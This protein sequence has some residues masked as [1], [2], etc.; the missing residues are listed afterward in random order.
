M[1][2]IGHI[3]L[4]SQAAASVL[5]EFES[6][7]DRDYADRY[8][9]PHRQLQSLYSRAL[10]RYLILIKFPEIDCRAKIRQSKDGR[11]YLD[12]PGGRREID[13]SLSHSHDM[14]GAEVSSVGPIGVDIEYMKQQ[15]NFTAM[16]QYAFNITEGE[17]S[18]WNDAENFYSL[19]TVL[20]SLVKANFMANGAA[21]ELGKFDALSEGG[22]HYLTLAGRVAIIGHKF[23][24]SY[25]MGLAASPAHE[26][27]EI[28]ISRAWPEPRAGDQYVTVYEISV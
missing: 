5:K 10:L 2:F 14:V 18:A 4:T 21:V 16:A 7:D 25:A 26:D 11:P 15:R 28:S 12:L 8:R 20:E 19:W 3:N 1:L 23:L 6:K 13:I 9:R 22:L 17:A 24:D 27:F